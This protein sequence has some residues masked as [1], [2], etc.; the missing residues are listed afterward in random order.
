[1]YSN[2]W[3][4]KPTWKLQLALERKCQTLRFCGKGTTRYLLDLVA[5]WALHPPP[6]PLPLPS[7]QSLAYLH[8]LPLQI[9]L[10]QFLLFWFLYLQCYFT[11]DKSVRNTKV[12]V[13]MKSCS[14]DWISFSINHVKDHDFPWGGRGLEERQGFYG[15]FW[16]TEQIISQFLPHSPLCIVKQCSLMYTTQHL[17]W[18]QYKLSLN[19]LQ[20]S[21]P[22]TMQTPNFPHCLCSGYVKS[23]ISGTWIFRDES[24]SP[25]A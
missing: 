16:G 18:N 17:V 1:M 4:T 6:P 14:T 3:L 24:T 22:S 21:Y 7:L 13:I 8:L 20:N 10:L 23:C 25:L 12:M 5:D 15:I 9:H 11:D 19:H 2:T